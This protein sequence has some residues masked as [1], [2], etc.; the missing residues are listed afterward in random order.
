MNEGKDFEQQFQA[1]LES[2][3]LY[4]V[5][6][7]D[8]PSS[9]GAQT[10]GIVRFT[11]NNPYDFIAYNYPYYYA[12]ELKSTKSTSLSFN[13]W[14]KGDESYVKTP[15]IKKHQIEG[16]SK[17]YSHKGVFSGF[18]INFRDT[19]KKPRTYYLS[20]FDFN[21]FLKNTTKKS[22]NEKDII[23]YGG[24]II[25]QDLKKVKYSFR[26]KEFIKTLTA[27]EGINEQPTT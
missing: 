21:T 24:I 11:L 20:I 10:Q 2:E 3:G 12:L 5:R 13:I 8:S 1:S 23:E 19:K 7:Q 4:V 27:R 18:I 25:E 14:N 26:I 22:I 15:N 16:L 9:F 6:L 17:A